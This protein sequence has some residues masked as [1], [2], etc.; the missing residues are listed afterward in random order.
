MKNRYEPATTDTV[1]SSGVTV[2]GNVT[3]ENDIWIDGLLEGNIKSQGIVTVGVNA[4]IA[5]NIKARNIRLSGQVTGDLQAQETVALEES[6]R[7]VGN[8][9][10]VNLSV[11]PGAILVGSVAM[12]AHEDQDRQTSE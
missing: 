9:H 12:P 6:G 3:S 8:I 2:K 1:I 10:T 11:T 5:G 4:Q 7:L